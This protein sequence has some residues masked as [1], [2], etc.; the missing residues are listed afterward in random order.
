MGAKR[1]EESVLEAFAVEVFAKL[2]V[3]TETADLAVRS[4]LDASLM[5]IDSHGIEALDMYVTHIQ[6]G[7]LKANAEPIRTGGSPGVGLWDMQHGFGLASARKIMAQAV[8]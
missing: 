3:L 8:A 6:R 2:G 5:A 1:F 4:M 7:G